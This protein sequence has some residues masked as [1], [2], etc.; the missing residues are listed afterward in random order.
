MDYSKLLTI[1]D[2]QRDLIFAVEK[3]IWENPETGY[4]EWKTD[5]YLSEIFTSL[6][7]R[8]TK[9]GN[10]P[11]FITEID[12]GRPGPCVL[13]FGEMDSLICPDHPDADKETGAVHSCGHHGQCAALVGIA[14]SLKAPGALDGLCGKIRLCAVPAEELIEQTYREELV[15]QGII[16]Y[17][18]GKVE[19]L[20][21]GLL[22]G[23]DIAMMVHGAT[24]KA[25]FHVRTASNG[26]FTKNII[27]RGVAAHAGGSPQ[28]GVNALYMANVAMTAVNALRETFNDDDYIRYHPIITKGGVATNAIPD[29]V[30][31]ETY[32]RGASLKAIESVNRKVNRALAASAASIGGKVTIVDHFGYMPYRQDP[33]LL[34]IAMDAGRAIVPPEKV[35]YLNET[36]KGCSDM[37]DI[38]AVM[39]ACQPYTGGA[40]GHNH[41]SDYFVADKER[42]CVNSTKLQLV[43]LAMLLE[44]GAEKAKKVI[45]EKNTVFSSKEEYFRKVDSVNAEIDAVTYNPDGTITLSF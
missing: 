45:A 34:D 30:E 37:G 24:S 13:V 14:A 36:G 8:L 27:F 35:V 21:R 15:K 39:P 2:S 33:N 29:R 12:T 32:V 42:L 4:R 41:G 10:I 7:Y 11:G 28:L 3:R 44:N 9:A 40:V 18:G 26:C 43:M 38:I 17:Y 25:D 23:C 31:M 5:R 19:F 6:G 22:D 20:Y 16:H 1:A